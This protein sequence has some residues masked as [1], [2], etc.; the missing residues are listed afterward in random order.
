MTSE[1]PAYNWPTIANTP[2]STL[3]TIT[4][5]NCATCRISLGNLLFS[6]MFLINFINFLA[7]IHSLEISAYLLLFDFDER[8]VFG[9]AHL[10]RLKT[11]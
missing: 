6:H 11:S 4:R 8:D 1:K 5:I 10:N 3:H 9:Q 2:F 7:G